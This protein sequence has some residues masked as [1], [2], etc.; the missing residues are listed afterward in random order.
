[1]NWEEYLL[2]HKASSVALAP[3]VGTV[4]GSSHSAPFTDLTIDGLEIN[5]VPPPRPTRRRS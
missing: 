4:D 2:T 5:C 3:G 1:M